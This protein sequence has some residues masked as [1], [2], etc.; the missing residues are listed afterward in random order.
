[1]TSGAE[2]TFE[3]LPLRGYTV[4]FPIFSSN[5][6]K[7]YHSGWTFDFTNQ[8]RRVRFFLLLQSILSREISLKNLKK[9]ETKIWLFMWLT[10]T[11]CNETDQTPL[12]LS[13][14]RWRPDSW[15][16]FWRWCH[17]VNFNDFKQVSCLKEKKTELQ[18]LG[19]YCENVSNLSSVS[20]LVLPSLGKKIIIEAKSSCK[21]QRKLYQ[22]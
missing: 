9:R 20:L 12:H 19:R 18:T 21:R 3:L 5:K 2:I 11:S 7:Y 1:M 16:L 6:D 4:L 22:K 17:V 15:S 13:L 10:L 8:R 14:F